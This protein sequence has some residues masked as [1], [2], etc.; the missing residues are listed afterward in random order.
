MPRSRRREPRCLKCT[1]DHKGC[2][3]FK[4]KLPAKK[5][6]QTDTGPSIKQPAPSKCHDSVVPQSSLTPFLS[7]VVDENPAL[8]MVVDTRAAQ[9]LA[10]HRKYF[11]HTV[12]SLI[13]S[14]DRIIGRLNVSYQEMNCLL[15]ERCAQFIELGEINTRL[16]SLQTEPG[17]QD[18]AVDNNRGEGGSGQVVES[19]GNGENDGE[20]EVTAEADDDGTGFVD[21]FASSS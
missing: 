16:K 14:R 2:P 11:H 10:H 18:E 6:Q 8:S 7:V 15:M 21:R 4:G 17:A 13:R 1:N 9:S 12:D 20:E 19:G 3:L 5:R